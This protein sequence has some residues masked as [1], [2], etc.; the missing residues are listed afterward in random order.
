[1]PRNPTRRLHGER[2]NAVLSWAAVAVALLAGG[3]GI[4]EGRAH[5]LVY[6]ATL[7]AVVLAPAVALESRRAALPWEISAFALVPLVLAVPSPDPFVRQLTLY[8]GAAILA[9]ALTLELHALTEISLERLLAAAF[10]T[11]LSATIAATWATATWLRDHVAGTEIVAGND[12]VMWLLVAAVAAGPVAGT[13]FDRYYRHFPGEELVSAPV[14]GIEE[15]DF[16][17][18]AEIDDRP[19]LEA[20][21]PVSGSVQRGLVW[22]MRTGLVG[23][24]VAGLAA[25]DPGIVS[26][27]ASMLAVSFVPTLLRRRYD[28]PFDA[29]LVLWVT[30]AAFLHALGS[31]YLYEQ[32]FWWHNVTHPLSAT[33]VGAIGYV[34]IRTLD[35]HRPE[36]HLPPGLVPA[37]VVVFVISFGV[38][39]EIG[40]FGFDHFAAATG[41]Q[42]P[43][44][45]H[46]LD[47]TMSD[48]VFNTLG[49]IVVA[50]WGL[51][52][53]TDLTDA[54]TD[55]VDGR[56]GFD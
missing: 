29:G 18:I 12:Q 23:I 13:I 33:L 9:L 31:A 46:G 21:L 11:M 28:L 36:I 22:A 30:L 47:D 14:D 34:A 48:L 50:I 32:T 52:Y 27:G 43:L 49:G 2:S 37:F 8:A 44:S 15:T 19:T 40:E 17:A 10:V 56:P 55:L 3:W 54:V 4:L 53:L 7:A 38:F 16:A 5:E 25:V 24:V 1:M 42:M 51:P 41:L 26:N 35:E 6:A 39:W 45:Q 20:R